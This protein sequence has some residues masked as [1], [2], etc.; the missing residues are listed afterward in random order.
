MVDCVSASHEWSQLEQGRTPSLAM[1][2]TKGKVETA[3]YLVLP[4]GSAVVAPASV[5]AARHQRQLPGDLGQL[6]P[7]RGAGEMFP[8]HKQD[9]KLNSRGVSVEGVAAGGLTA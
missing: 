7:V 4:V 2:L 5:A 9:S 8:V 6:H 3:A 1:K